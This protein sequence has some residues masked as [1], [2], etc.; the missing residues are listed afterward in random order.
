MWAQYEKSSELIIGKYNVK[1]EIYVGPSASPVTQPQ[2]QKQG[3]G[4]K[5]DGKIH[6]GND[7]QYTAGLGLN[8]GRGGG[9]TRGGGRG[10]HGHGHGHGHGQA[11]APGQGYIEPGTVPPLHQQQQ[12][13]QQQP[14]EMSGVYYA[15]RYIK[16]ERC[17]NFDNNICAFQPFECQF[18]HM[19]IMGDNCNIIHCA[20]THPSQFNQKMMEFHVAQIQTQ[21]QQQQQQQ[22]QQ[23]QQTHGPKSWSNQI[24]KKG[25]QKQRSHQSNEVMVRGLRKLPNLNINKVRND[26]F[27][28]FKNYGCLSINDVIVK[29]KL[30]GTENHPSIA[31][32][33]LKT[34]KQ[35]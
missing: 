11:Q 19:C 18:E 5:P 20:N 17:I 10:G 4:R 14:Q 15:P 33:N 12:Q 3:G 2:K 13:Q 24:P 9:R 27:D 26:L 23:Q 25:Q 35:V 7:M 1:L 21:Q 6:F 28:I 29:T 22:P 30:Q 34:Q 16:P 32:V 8:R 31:F